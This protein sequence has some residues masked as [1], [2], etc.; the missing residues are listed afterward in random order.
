MSAMKSGNSAT[1]DASPAVRWYSVAATQSCSCVDRRSGPTGP[2]WCF[3]C[4]LQLMQSRPHRQKNVV[5]FM[6][7]LPVYL[8]LEVRVVDPADGSRDVGGHGVPPDER[9]ERVVR[10]RRGQH[11]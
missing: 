9:P 10:A 4:P 3:S 5:A 11:L 1:V 7:E 2:G 8:R 6:P